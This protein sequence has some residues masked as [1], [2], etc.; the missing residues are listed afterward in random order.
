MLPVTSPGGDGR[1][2]ISDARNLIVGAL[3][4]SQP[5]DSLFVCPVVSSSKALI[6]LFPAHQ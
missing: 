3:V 4:M 2:A 1:E 5:D 6:F